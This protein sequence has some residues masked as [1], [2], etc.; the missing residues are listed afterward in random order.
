[1]GV[2]TN[3][4]IYHAVSNINI[5]SRLTEAISE[6]IEFWTF[7]IPKIQV[8]KTN[9]IENPLFETGVFLKCYSLL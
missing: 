2:F 7:Y 4:F 5:T 9:L 3:L 1:M 6:P 8:D